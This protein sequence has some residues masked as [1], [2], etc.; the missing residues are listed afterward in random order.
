[1]RFLVDNA[2]SPSLAESL[3]QNGHDAIHVRDI[4]L[5][6]AQDEVIFARSASESRVLL[7]ADTDFG[8]L[9]ALRRETKPAVI[10][11]R[12][13]SDRRPAQQSA[14]LLT[15]MNLIQK[16]LEQGCIVVFDEARM[17]IRTLPI[18]E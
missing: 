10:L 18:G 6:T 1:M 11:F 17:R 4:G 7:S 8:A 3:R 12:R 2:L 5:E 13:R 9:L 14:L 16:P 15:N